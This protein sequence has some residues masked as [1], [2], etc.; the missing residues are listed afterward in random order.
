MSRYKLLTGLL[1]SALLVG[2]IGVSFNGRSGDSE[3]PDIPPISRYWQD[4]QNWTKNAHKQLTLK[5]TRYLGGVQTVFVADGLEDKSVKEKSAIMEET[6]D[7]IKSRL[8]QYGLP[9]VVIRS[10]GE[11]KFEIKFPGTVEPKEVNRLIGST[12]ALEFRKVIKSFDPDTG[13][14]SLDPSEEVLSGKE[15][16]GQRRSYIVKKAPL[17]TGNVLEDVRVKK[18]QRSRN[19]FYVILQFT[20]GGAKEF[21]RAINNLE[22]DEDRVAIVVDDVVQSAPVISQGIWDTAKRSNSIETATISGDFSKGEAKRLALI[23]RVGPLPVEIKIIESNVIKE[24]QDEEIFRKGLS[25]LTWPFLRL[26]WRLV[27]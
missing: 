10:L 2:L 13:V 8:Y 11:G 5:A 25:R 4:A 22:P 20:G 27:R 1:I 16:E 12:G 26:T 7:I 24:K 3:S 21:A 19:P 17:L 9:G 14:A 6:I 15:R 18:S 23:L